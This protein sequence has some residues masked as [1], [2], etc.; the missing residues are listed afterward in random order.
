[1]TESNA[2]LSD[3][4]RLPKDGRFVE[5]AYELMDTWTSGSVGIEGVEAVLR[6]ME[7]HPD[8]DYGSPGPLVHFVERFYGHGYEQVL[9]NSIKRQP[10]A[11]T[12]WM[13][14]AVVNGTR[15]LEARRR[16]M[17]VLAEAAEDASLDSFVRS[18]VQELLA[19]QPA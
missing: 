1:M 11:H 2:Y 12:M 8:V 9:I 4:E 5:R 10:R 14:I 6:F 3:L 19:R 18:E 16:L 17:A 7:A 15:D 13:L